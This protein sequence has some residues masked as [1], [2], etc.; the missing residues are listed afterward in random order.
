[1]D[2]ELL[3]DILAAERDIRLQINALEQQTAERLEALKQE[4]DQ[5]LE[6]EST[7]LQS[8]LDLARTSAEESAHREAEAL[9]AEARAFALRLENLATLE[10]D[11]VVL[12][13]LARILPGGER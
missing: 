13:H 3:T 2:D 6:S 11:T 7:A 5:M 12:R 4:L 9:M 10:L 1:M 8:E